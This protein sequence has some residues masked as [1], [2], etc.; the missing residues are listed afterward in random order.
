M[1]RILAVDWDRHEARYALGT[2][3]GGR[4]KVHVA[5]SIPLVDVTEGGDE[6]HPDLAGSL[7]AA[8]S[9]LKLGRTPVLVGVERSS[10]ELLHFTL[11]P[12]KDNE[13]PELVAN[14]AMR[15]SQLIGEQSVLDFLPIDDNPE[16]PRSVIAA[17][18]SPGE[19]ERIQRTCEAAE[20]KPARVLLRPFA[21]ASLFVKTGAPAEEVY[22]LVNRFTDE[23]DLS[24]VVDQRPVFFRTV[25]LPEGAGEEQ[26]TERLLAEI[27]RTLAAAPQ[28]HLRGET[29]QCVYVLGGADDHQGL[30]DGIRDDL[31]LPASVFDPFEAL[32]VRDERAPENPGR[33]APV[34]GML[35]DEA[36]GSHAIDF[37][38]P[39]KMPQPVNRG[40][41]AVFAGG[42][43]AALILGVAF[44]TWS[45]WSDIQSENKVLAKRAAELD[46]TM[47]KA[48][49]QKK[50]IDAV[51]EWKARDVIWLDE[52]RDLSLR[53]PSTRDVVVSRMSLSPSQSGGGAINLE[54]LMRGPDIL[55]KLENQ[56]RD[57][58]RRVQSK[59]VQERKLE[60]D[61]TW[62]FETSLSVARRDADR[63]QS[64]YVSHLP[65]DEK[66][67]TKPG[68]EP[69]TESETLA[70]AGTPSPPAKVKKASQ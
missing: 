51:R 22:L 19:L 32:G 45:T 70:D 58:Y 60:R 63:D 3:S 16:A 38:H 9:E 47:K 13:L 41:I 56:V 48:A 7:A 14:Q 18:L 44:N 8:M 4:V 33:F 69:G 34:L 66:P 65:E 54:G 68:T 67:G 37:L 5:A 27:K 26:A 31:F 15:E 21:S 55:V 52:L 12:A 29:V 46:K 50:L 1:A 39:R 49:E 23:A 61:Y 40:R 25:R 42:V 11:P 53:F 64:R 35:L 24:I 17:A 20:L 6:P 30:I 59:R 2:T 28:T 57:R 36:T 62:L 43:L 10:I